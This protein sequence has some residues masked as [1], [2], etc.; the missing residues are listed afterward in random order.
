MVPR[1]FALRGLLRIEAPSR[2]DALIAAHRQLSARGEVTVLGYRGGDSWPLSFS[3][4]EHAAPPGFAPSGLQG[5]G[6]AKDSLLRCREINSKSARLFVTMVKLCSLVDAAMMVSWWMELR[7]TSTPC[8]SARRARTRPA[9]RQASLDGVSTVLVDGKTA[10]LILY[11]CKRCKRIQSDHVEQATRDKRSREAD[12]AILVTT[13]TRRGYTGLANDG[14]VLVVSPL[15]VIALAGL[16]RAQLLQMSRARFSRSQKEKAAAQ[17]LEYITGAMFRGPLEDAI[18][19]TRKARGLL[20]KEAKAHF[21][22]WQERWELYQT[23]D[24][25]LAS[26]SHNSERISHGEKPV[27]VGRLKPT[28]LTL[29]AAT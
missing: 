8:S 19:R 20:E 16:V 22:V 9:C 7:R 29:P 28:L 13:G 11:E 17:A 15:G 10:G 18:T 26:L 14:P 3:E 1:F 12:F 2:A 23:V 24:M 5:Y 21:Q 27:P 6:G 25:D 4:P